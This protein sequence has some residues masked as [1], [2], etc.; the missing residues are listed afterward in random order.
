[1]QRLKRTTITLVA[2]AGMAVAS[3]FVVAPRG[4]RRAEGGF[5]RTPSRARATAAPIPGSTR[6]QSAITGAPSGATINVC[7]G[8]YAQ[9]LTIT[10]AP[11]L[12]GQGVVTAALPASVADSTT[13][14][15]TAPGTGPESPDQMVSWCAGMSR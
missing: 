5:R 13:S 15:D 8:T 2:A 6:H 7:A 4:I 9:Q 14:C 10:K 3:S 11:P 1:M 12:V